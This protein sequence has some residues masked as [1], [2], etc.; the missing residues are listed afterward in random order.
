MKRIVTDEQLKSLWFKYDKMPQLMHE[1]GYRNH[2]GLCKRAK[3]LGLPNW[4][5]RIAYLHKKGLIIN[6]NKMA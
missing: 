2:G 4:K 5:G 3:G 6:E 1:L